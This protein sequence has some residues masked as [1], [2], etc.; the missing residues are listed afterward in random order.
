M[1]NNILDKIKINNLDIFPTKY[2][3]A[4][5]A[6]K[7]S[8][9]NLKQFG[10][11]YFSWINF[12]SVKAWKYHTQMTL[13]LVVPVGKVKF[14]FYCDKKNKFRIEEIGENNY[15]LLTVPPRIW[16]GFQGLYNTK[17]L[18]TN[19]ADIEH[20]PKETLG[21]DHKEIKFEWEE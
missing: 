4:M 20:D 10:E 11:V 17:S 5:H 13:N 19:I 15:A 9:E 7:N 12:K 21:K 3:N 6:I 14:V 1:N 8:N 2:G 16:F 18:V